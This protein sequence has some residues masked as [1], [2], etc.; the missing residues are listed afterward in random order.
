MAYESCNDKTKLSS[1]GD[2]FASVTSQTTGG[3]NEFMFKEISMD[4]I[5]PLEGEMPDD[6]DDDVSSTYDAYSSLMTG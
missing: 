6:D 5:M 2:D 4:D 1:S 3:G